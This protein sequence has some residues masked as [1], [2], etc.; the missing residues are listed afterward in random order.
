MSS[1][2][3]GNK[4]EGEAY[5]STGDPCKKSKIYL[6]NSDGEKLSETIVDEE[7]YFTLVPES[8]GEYTVVLDAGEGHTVSEIVNM[9]GEAV[10]EEEEIVEESGNYPS[11]QKEFKS[12]NNKIKALKKEIVRLENKNSFRDILGGFGYIFGIFGIM[13]FIK[14]RK[15]KNEK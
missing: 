12:V 6:K 9:D 5:F 2:V 8:S 4:I 14:S 7:G 13:G 11:L 3:E 15:E 10:E 1:S